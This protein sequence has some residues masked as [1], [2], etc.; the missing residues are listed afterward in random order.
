MSEPLFTRCEI[1]HED[2]RLLVVNKPHSVLSHPN[3][4]G[5]RDVRCAFEG[6][7][8]LKNK[9]FDTPA[10]K[11]WLVHRL[12]QDTSGVLVAAR[13]EDAA[14]LCREAFENDRVSKQYTALVMGGI[15]QTEGRWLD[16][17]T[18]AREA[19]RVR[20]IV[21]RGAPPNA[22]LHYRVTGYSSS[23]KVSLLDITLITGRTHQIRVQASSRHHAVVGDDVYGAFDFNRRMKREAGLKRLFLHAREI[24][25]PHP[26]TK[27]MLTVKAPLPDDLTAVLKA[28][29]I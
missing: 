2:L 12:D 29:G 7:Y 14:A 4:Q 25:L 20:T 8:D 3:P 5:R 24:A 26:D 6:R 27:Q 13:D 17:L 15:L 16:H 1:L 21:K 28:A 11:L 10:G 18:T 19:H 9:R 23:R 22:E